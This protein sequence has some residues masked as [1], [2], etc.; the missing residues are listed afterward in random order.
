MASYRPTVVKCTMPVQDSQVNLD[1]VHKGK[2]GAQTLDHILEM[3]S[4]TY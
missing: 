1:W 3:G 2:A 4:P